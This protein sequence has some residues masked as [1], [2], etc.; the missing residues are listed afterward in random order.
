[1]K[2]DDVFICRSKQRYASRSAARTA[3]AEIVARYFGRKRKRNLHSY[4]CR[5]CHGYHVTG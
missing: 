1:M 5:H 4:L 3:I 2:A